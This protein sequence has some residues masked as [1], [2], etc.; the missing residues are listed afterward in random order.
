M[1]LE[2][3]RASNKRSNMIQQVLEDL[4]EK[5][6]QGED[7]GCIA[8][9]VMTD[10]SSKLSLCMLQNHEMSIVKPYVGP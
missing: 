9:Q 8:A 1:G 2:G 4:K 6:S 10:K 7:T 5:I 3:Q